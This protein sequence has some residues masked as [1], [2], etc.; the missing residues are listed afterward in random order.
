[1][2]DSA[3]MLIDGIARS[4][5][6]DAF[7]IVDSSTEAAVETVTLASKRDIDDAVRAARTAFDGGGWR[8]STPEERAKLLE[9][10]GQTLLDRS[11]AIGET[12]SRENGNPIATSILIQAL[13][14]VALLHYFAQV[15]REFEFDEAPRTG[16]A[17]NPLLVTRE[18]VGV[19]AAVVPWNV[20][21]AIALLKLA[22][23]LA[24]GCTIVVKP[25]PRTALDAQFLVEAV[26]DAGFPAGVV[27]IVP[28]DRDVS[29]YLVT[30]PD[31]D[32]VSLT[33]SAAT[34]KRVGA[35]CGELVRP[36][37]LELGGKSAAIVCEDAVLDDVVAGL[38]P[39]MTMINGQACVAQTRLL[40]PTNRA[41][42]F[43]DAFATAFSQLRVGN[44]LDPQTEVGPL[45]SARQRDR[46]LGYIEQGV[47]QGAVVAVGGKAADV[48][49]KGYFVQPTLLT[50]VHP[51]SV[52]AQEEIFGP[53][54]TVL[55]YDDI[56]QAVAIA[57]NSRYGLSG[58]VW[59]A[60]SERGVQIARRVQTGTINV[61]YFGT[62]IAAPFG[63][64]KDSGLG[65]ENGPEALNA[66]LQYKS[67]GVKDA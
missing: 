29:E 64:Y 10:L 15:T 26:K 16:F 23:A 4:G 6:G 17:G 18:P 22:P 33:G 34:G 8:Q 48:D 46:V 14:P 43:V 53:V 7:T 30:H 27:N 9:A 25:D 45:V 28:A 35:L 19:A 60:D 67:I 40:L 38:L 3:G 51:D 42:E 65:R 58:S 56:D 41:P 1:M 39:G 61:N 44:A 37:T 57:N 24:A 12:I 54:V 5:S 55:T 59:T 11:Q 13:S 21:I 20:P 62:E 49:G 32:K 31:V 50:D 66:Y 63:G 36:I 47:T 52:V 2:P